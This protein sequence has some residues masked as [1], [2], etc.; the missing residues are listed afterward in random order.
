MV[1]HFLG[2]C[3]E[4]VLGQSNSPAPSPVRDAKPARLSALFEDFMLSDRMS[5][6]A[7]KGYTNFGVIHFL[8]N[9]WMGRYLSSRL[10]KSIELGY[11]LC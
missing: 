9:Y 10:K 7:D 2:R 5:K 4:G 8:V 6:S 3:L 11:F 1:E